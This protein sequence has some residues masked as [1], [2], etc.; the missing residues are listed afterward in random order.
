MGKGLAR[1]ERRK[2]GDRLR[3]VAGS[4]LALRFRSAGH[5]TQN[6]D[7]PRHDPALPSRPAARPSPPSHSPTPGPP[8]RVRDPSCDPGRFGALPSARRAVQSSPV[9]SSAAP[10]LFQR[11]VA[12]RAGYVH[13]A[14]Y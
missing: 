3:T 13:A 8:Q 4:V 9:S 2:R 6:D 14:I 12:A 11:H 7:S 10:L 1:G 5:P